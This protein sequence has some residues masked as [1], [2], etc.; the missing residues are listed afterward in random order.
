MK[1]RRYLFAQLPESDSGAFYFQFC[2]RSCG[3]PYSATPAR[4]L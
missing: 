3:T 4:T 1:E 2:L